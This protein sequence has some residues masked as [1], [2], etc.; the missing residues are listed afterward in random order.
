M[1]KFI[2]LNVYRVRVN[3][4]EQLKAAFIQLEH[5]SYFLHSWGWKITLGQFIINGEITSVFVYLVKQYFS[6][7]TTYNILSS[8]KSLF[9]SW[10]N[11]EIYTLSLFVNFVMFLTTL[12]YKKIYKM[13]LNLYYFQ[14]LHL[15]WNADTGQGSR[16][17]IKT[18]RT[19]LQKELGEHFGN[20]RLTFNR[21]K[22]SV[23]WWLQI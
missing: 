3:R 23:N 16:R 12:L 21:E 1:K 6:L 10:G 9:W 22:D 4:S 20:D 17:E 7:F 19:F 5:F 8:I 2:I 13:H 14:P 18:W 11:N 15:E